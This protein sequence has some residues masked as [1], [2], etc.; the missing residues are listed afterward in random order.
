MK[1]KTTL[2]DGQRSTLENALRVAVQSFREDINLL[3]TATPSDGAG[4]TAAARLITQFERQC[5]ETD[6]LGALL[7]EAAEITVTVDE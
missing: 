6:A 1:M 4:Q 2:D 5:A 3:R 7:A